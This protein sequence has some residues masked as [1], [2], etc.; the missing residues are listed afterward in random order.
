M[1]VKII[2][3]QQQLSSYSLGIIGDLLYLQQKKSIVSMTYNS[4][5]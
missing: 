3:K 5:L 2:E 1:H 4:S